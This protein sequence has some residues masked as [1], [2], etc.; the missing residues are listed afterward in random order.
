MR[1]IDLINP[2]TKTR[3]FLKFINNAENDC[4]ILNPFNI[5]EKVKICERKDD[6]K[7]R[8]CRR[9]KCRK[10]CRQ[11]IRQNVNNLIE[12]RRRETRTELEN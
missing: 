11:K 7:I 8:K 5:R 10:S 9:R 12:S 6:R 4:P 2:G 1:V 3:Y